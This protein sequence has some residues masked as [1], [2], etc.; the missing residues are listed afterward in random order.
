MGQGREGCLL[1]TFDE[2]MYVHS[3]SVIFFLE[4]ALKRRPTATETEIK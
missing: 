3:R 1:G 4:A 2:K